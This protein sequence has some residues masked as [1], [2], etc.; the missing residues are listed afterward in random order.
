MRSRISPTRLIRHRPLLTYFLLCYT[1]SAL[2]LVVIGPPE[3]HPTRGRPTTALVMFPVMVVAVALIGLLLTRVTQGAP[4]LRRI[5]ERFGVKVATRWYA[6]LLV[7]PLGILGVLGTLTLTSSSAYHPQFLVYGLAA[8]LVSGF[9][10][11][12]G[13]TGYA[14]PLM[15]AKW[16]WRRASL[17][18]GVLW[19]V[20][21]LPVVDSLGAASPHGTSW[22]AFFASFVALVAAM[23]VL[24]AWAYVNTGSLRLAQLLHAS[25][26]GF[27][28][29]LGAPAVSPRR[30][31]TWYA[32]YALLLWCVALLVM[33]RQRDPT[34]LEVTSAPRSPKSVSSTPTTSRTS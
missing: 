1:V 17:L 21:H 9:F 12:I 5:R 13:W 16:G 25:S 2:A 7:A 4:G 10:E 24:I 32:I 33:R 15:S 27:L 6:L 3:L 19:G 8:G 22:P 30:E 31:A 11:E 20:W 23:R 34:S 26:T 18:L 14:F 28:V 29:V